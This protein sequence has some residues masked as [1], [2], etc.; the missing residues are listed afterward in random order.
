M[1]TVGK[2]DSC[3]F[4]TVC[5]VEFFPFLKEFYANGI[6]FSVGNSEPEVDSD[7]VP[8]EEIKF[9]KPTSIAELVREVLLAS[10]KCIFGATP[11]TASM[12]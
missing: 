5:G 9:A 10:A 1:N 2:W 6:Q 3:V 4:Q 12:Y 11:R 8:E 7:V